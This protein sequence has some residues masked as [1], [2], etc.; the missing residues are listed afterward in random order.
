MNEYQ[1]F[2]FLDII[3]IL[4][5]VAQLLNMFGDEKQT[6]YIHKVIRAI[7]DE[8]QKLHNENDMIMKQN[9]EILNLLKEISDGI[10]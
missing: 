5:F 7:S 2:E 9:E 4:G 1:D 8:I 6:N 3:N 10:N